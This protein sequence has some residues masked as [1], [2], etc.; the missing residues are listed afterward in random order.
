MQKMI[1]DL[2]NLVNEIFNQ[3]LGKSARFY[4]WQDKKKNKYFY[5]TTKVEWKGKTRYLSG[6]YIYKK[7]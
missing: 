5:T 6:V 1:S 3:E 4:F 7:T 2:N